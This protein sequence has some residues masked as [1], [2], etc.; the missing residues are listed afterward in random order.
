VF[1]VEPAE[2]EWSIIILELV[3]IIVW[4]W[5]AIWVERDGLDKGGIEKRSRY[6]AI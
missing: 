4:G 5:Y 6:T 3:T 2:Y 1:T